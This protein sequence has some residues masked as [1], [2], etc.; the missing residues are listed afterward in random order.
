MEARTRYFD[1]VVNEL[2][3]SAGPQAIIEKFDELRDAEGR[4]KSD[5]VFLNKQGCKKRLTAARNANV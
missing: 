2:G 1:A 4:W 3:L 5:K